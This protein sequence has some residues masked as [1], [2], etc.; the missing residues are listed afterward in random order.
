MRRSIISAF[1]AVLAA[2]AVA[3]A[4]RAEQHRLQEDFTFKRIGVPPEG[5]TGRITVQIAPT[6][7]S[8]PVTTPGM[9]AVEQPPAGGQ[10]GRPAPDIAWFWGAVS[11]DLGASDPASFV[12]AETVL[13]NA[14]DDLAIP[15]PRL[16]DMGA[17]AERYG[18]QILAA[19]VG[20]PVSPA[21]VLA[22]IAV[23][24]AGDAQAV[25]RAGARGLMQLMPATAERFGV[26]DSF[27]TR[28]NI[29]GGVAYLGWLMEEFERDLI[30]VLAGYN[31]GEGAVRENGG[32]PPYPETRAY[33]PKVLAAWRVARG[34]CVTPPELPSDGCVF[35]I[36]PEG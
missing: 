14:P 9:A 16:R 36:K 32:V 19:S 4:P 11:P 1:M 5:A 3:G 30:M 12:K 18:A 10:V 15:Q 23:E 25:S 29:T 31:A 33:V 22:V 35:N 7:P 20:E 34:L 8:A 2:L 17:L 21:L 27:D 26:R 24:S 13:V 6:A 28:Q